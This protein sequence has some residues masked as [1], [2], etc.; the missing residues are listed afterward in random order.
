MI[1][2]KELRQNPQPYLESCQRRGVKFDFSAF[3]Q[4]DQTIINL[5]QEIDALRHQLKLESK[6]S[7]EQLAQMQ[8]VKIALKD[9][10]NKLAALKSEYQNQLLNIPNL[11]DDDIP[12]GGEEDARVEVEYYPDNFNSEVQTL[13]HLKISEKYQLLD[14]ST[15]SNVS[16]SKFYFGNSKFYL[17]TRSLF[18]YAQDFLLNLG[19][20][21]VSV[22]LL[23]N[24]AISR[25]TGYLPTIGEP[26]IYSLADDDLFLIATAEIPLTA[27][28]SGQV[29]DLTSPKL[30]ASN[31]PCFRREAGSYGKFSKGLYRVHQF[32]KTEF[33]IYSSP[34]QSPELLK[35]ILSTQE[36]FV[37]SLQLPYRVTKTAAGDMSAPAFAKYDLE[38][39][40]PATKDFRELTSCSNCSDYQARRLNIKYIN[41][42]G[43]TGFAHT[44]NGT[45]ATSSRTIIAILENYQDGAGNVLIP[46]VLQPYYKSEVL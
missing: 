46:E 12:D 4:L 33:Y 5:E 36:K 2:I 21:F 11:L 30:Y 43:E 42:Q 31:T 27:M 16:G 19:I 15:G 32:E 35:L 10:E 41:S 44:L 45:I 7:N 20:E 13:D 14:F 34:A 6:P 9:L 1:D 40:S 39:Y 18:N 29:L 3:L 38:Y 17:L 23:V 24:S 37:K 26:D 28:H 22:P 25:G 8:N